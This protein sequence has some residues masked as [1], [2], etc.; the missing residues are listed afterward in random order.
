MQGFIRKIQNFND[1]ALPLFFSLFLHF[2]IIYFIFLAG[3]GKNN[4]SSYQV[5]VND[6]LDSADTFILEE[7]QRSKERITRKISEVR[8]LKREAFSGKW[9]TKNMPERIKK[10]SQRIGIDIV[11]TQVSP[12]LFEGGHSSSEFSILIKLITSPRLVFE[13]II[14]ISYLV[15]D[16]TIHSD[17]KTDYFLLAIKEKGRKESRDFIITTMDCR[18]L[19][20][21]KL[22][23]QQFI[24][25]AKIEEG[26]YW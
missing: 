18:L 9:T 5:S 7:I 4:L 20:A 21:R 11:E 25:Q 3:S 24:S 17:F 10:A 15:G 16:G 13:D 22:S 1:I 12:S 23:A 26:K 6:K 14:L 19:Y 8:A 2:I